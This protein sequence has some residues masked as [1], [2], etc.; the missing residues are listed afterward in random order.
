MPNPIT[1]TPAC[2][3]P[4]KVA[5]WGR[6]G[7]NPEHVN[8]RA[9]A[10]VQL[11]G[12]ETIGVGALRAIV[13]NDWMADTSTWDPARPYLD[14]EEF[15]WVFADLRGYGRSK[16]LP[17]PFDLQQSV[18]DILTLADHL[19]WSKFSI[20]GHSMS[21]LVA[22]HLGQRHADRIEGAALLT[23]V[24]PAGFGA[25]E[26]RLEAFRAI[27]FFDDGQREESLDQRWGNRLSKGW[28]KF[29]AARWR[30][31]SSPDAVAAY[32]DMFA[33]EG[34]PDPKAH[35]N[36]P[37]LAITGEEDMEVMRGATVS[38]LLGPIAKTLTVV[39]FAQCSHYPMQELPPLTV[40]AV[41]RF[42]RGDERRP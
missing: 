24:P 2:E 37:V 34:L 33:K 22:M 23:P 1:S 38:K 12:H 29:K 27:A 4:P 21:T 25:D 15:T 42:L 9:E 18:T 35:I 41:E 39:P 17:G 40:A 3:Q 13:M 8:K 20:V 7:G 26:A 16:T 10:N 14:L 31:T 5:T 28:V 19:W 6:T 30:S 36:V 11:L 32:T